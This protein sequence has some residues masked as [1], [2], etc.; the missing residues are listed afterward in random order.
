MEYTF[1]IALRGYVQAKNEAAA[2]EIAKE[3]AKSIAKRADLAEYY[4]YETEAVS[5]EQT[6]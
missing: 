3:Q 4:I 5:V 2:L 6:K 1:T